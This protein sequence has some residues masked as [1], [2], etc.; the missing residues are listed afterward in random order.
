VISMGRERVKGSPQIYRY[1]RQYQE[2]PASRVFAP[3]AEAYRKA[4]LVEDAIEVAR[5]GLRHHPHFV[6][7][8]VALARALFDHRKYTEVVEILDSLVQDA[9]DNLVA[10]RLLAESQLM[11]GQLAPAL[12]SFKMLLYFNPHDQETAKMVWEL[13]SQIYEGG[14]PLIRPGGGPESRPESPDPQTGTPRSLVS[15]KQMKSWVKR[16]E[17]LQVLLQRVERYRRSYR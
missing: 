3:L 10:Q 12:T 6:G 2:D 16:V 14:E 9:P 11:L 8:K 4:G 1:L 15:P 5:D 13:E 7:G 17:Y